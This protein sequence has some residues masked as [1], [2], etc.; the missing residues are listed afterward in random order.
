MTDQANI[1]PG[2]YRAMVTEG[3]NRNMVPFI[4]EFGGGY[5]GHQSLQSKDPEINPTLYQY[6]ALRALVDLSFQQIEANFLHATWWNFDLYNSESFGDHWNQEDFSFLG[7]DRIPRNWDRFAR[8]Y[9]LRSSATPQLLWFDAQSKNFALTLSGQP[10]GAPT[11]IFIPQYL[12]YSTGFELR[13][14]SATVQW[15][16]KRQMLAWWPDPQQAE[17]AIILSPAQGFNS[18]V[19]PARAKELL[20]VA[21]NSQRQFNTSVQYRVGIGR[22][23]CPRVRHMLTPMCISPP[24]NF[25]SSRQAALSSLAYRSPAQ[26]VLPGG[27]QSTKTPSFP[28]TTAPTHIHIALLVGWV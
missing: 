11:M 8:P 9:P 18:D 4:T 3:R 12:Q 13:A 14:T 2:F 19:L 24:V 17:H 22:S 10:V 16:E 5:G 7:P 20:G 28:S 26:T 1:W 27:T 25:T 6:R 21:L 15:D 23:G